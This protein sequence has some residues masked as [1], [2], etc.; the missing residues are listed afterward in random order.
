MSRYRFFLAMLL[1][2][3]IALCG[4][5]SSLS[6]GS[7]KKPTSE[8]NIKI[9]PNENNTSKEITDSGNLSFADQIKNI[10]DSVDKRPPIN[11]K[12]GST[13]DIIL[14]ENPTTGYSWNASVTSGLEIVNDSYNPPTSRLMGAGGEHQWTIRGTA[15]G[16]QTFSAVYRRP[17]EAPSPDDII[18]VQHFLVTA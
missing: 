8:E 1:V 10:Q 4:C 15:V 7:E 5:T 9:A 12:I 13:T 11:L 18:Y 14:K 2:I 6:S 3:G 17:W 16:N